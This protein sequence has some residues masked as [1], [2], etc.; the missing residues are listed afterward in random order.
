M[1]KHVLQKV[2]FDQKLFRKELIKSKNWLKR[3]ELHMLKA[4]ALVTFAGVYD[5]LIIEVLGTIA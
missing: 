3:D 1:S 2:S 5:E 4:W